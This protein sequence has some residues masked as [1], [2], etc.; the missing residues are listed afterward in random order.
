MAGN[1]RVGVLPIRD[2]EPMP[3][4]AFNMIASNTGRITR[5]LEPTDASSCPHR[6]MDARI[7]APAAP[8]N[9]FRHFQTETVLEEIIV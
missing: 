8:S 3:D 6:Y 5:H 2:R 7:P 9:E 1:A 4:D